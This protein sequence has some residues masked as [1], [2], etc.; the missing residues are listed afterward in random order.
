M[1]ED[2]EKEIMK[3]IHDYH[4]NVNDSL[5]AIKKCLLKS[6]KKIFKLTHLVS[7]MPMIKKHNYCSLF[8]SDIDEKLT[9]LTDNTPMRMKKVIIKSKMI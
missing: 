4:N 5:L 1:S 3:M 9:Y 2:D 7:L 8:F 6:M